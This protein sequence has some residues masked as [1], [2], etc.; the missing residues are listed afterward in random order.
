MEDGGDVVKRRG[1]GDD[2]GC[3]VSDQ[4]RLMKGFVTGTEKE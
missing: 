2:A 4:L 3:R 1:S